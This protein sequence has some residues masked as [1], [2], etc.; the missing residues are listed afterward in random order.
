[1][2]DTVEHLVDWSPVGA[3]VNL[4]GGDAGGTV[5]KMFKSDDPSVTNVT[6]KNVTGENEIEAQ[7]AQRRLARLS[8]YFTSPTGVMDSMTG[9]QGV[10]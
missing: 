10:F 8:R 1:M 2:G 4:F 9:S 6:Q 5:G 7:A 3:L